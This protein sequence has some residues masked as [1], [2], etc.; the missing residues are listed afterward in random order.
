M[1]V[2]TVLISLAITHGS[3]W[4][5]RVRPSRRRSLWEHLIWEVFPRDDQQRDYVRQRFLTVI[6]VLPI[7]ALIVFLISERLAR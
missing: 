4:L 6:V 1:M 7:T 5:R 3:L 2:S